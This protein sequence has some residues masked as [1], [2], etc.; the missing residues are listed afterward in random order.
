MYYNGGKS[1]LVSFL[2]S[3]M[4][5]VI[6]CVIFIFVVPLLG[7]GGNQVVPDL[8]GSTVE[9]A[10]V[11]TETRGLLIVVGGEEENDK[12]DVNLICRQVPLQGSVV[13]GRST[14]TVYLSKGSGDIVLPDFERMGLSEAT[15]RL[16]EIGLRI[17]EVRSEEHDTIDKDK[18]ISTSPRAGSRVKKD[19]LIGVV[20]SRGSQTVAVPRVTGKALSTAKRLIEDAGF[21]VGNVSWEVSTEYNVGIVMRQ[22]PSA[23]A[24]AKKGS[25]INLVVATVLE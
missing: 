24:N 16:S 18:I 14:V 12:M 23:G 21:T 1:F 9:Q 15:I 2:V 17:G 19:D 6:V 20:L 7:G 4:T 25:A 11:I 8:V 5:S 3:L 13:R 10:R 22:N